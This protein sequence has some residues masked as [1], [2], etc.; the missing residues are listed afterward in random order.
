[1]RF[2]RVIYIYFILLKVV[3]QWSSQYIGNEVVI[4]INANKCVEFSKHLLHVLNEH[5][6]LKTS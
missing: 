3:L 6:Y 1:M 5:Y 4:K 2:N